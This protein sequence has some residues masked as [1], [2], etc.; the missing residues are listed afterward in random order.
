MG[1]EEIDPGITRYGATETRLQV[2]QGDKVAHAAPT[3]AKRS[4]RSARLAW[5]TFWVTQEFHRTNRLILREFIGEV[6]VLSRA[7]LTFSLV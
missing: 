6:R 4:R 3:D 5:V 1:K 7:F 2:P